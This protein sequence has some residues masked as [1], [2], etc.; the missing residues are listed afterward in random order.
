MSKVLISGS[1]INNHSYW[2]NYYRQNTPTSFSGDFSNNIEVSKS[3][4][5]QGYLMF[6]IKSNVKGKNTVT[7]LAKIC[8]LGSER[9]SFRYYYNN[10]NVEKYQG[11]SDL[12]CLTAL[13]KKIKNQ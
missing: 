1:K 2:E 4:E 12:K 6:K 3:K 7:D 10:L 5:Q 11:N 8:K 13:N 9:P